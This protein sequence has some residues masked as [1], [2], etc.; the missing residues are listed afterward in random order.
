M[1]KILIVDDDADM[2]QAGRRV[3]EKEG[4]AV[5][6]APNVGAGLKALDKDAPDLL[7]LGVMMEEV[8]DGLVFARAVRRMGLT[9]P[10]LMLTSVNRAMGVSI[11]KDAEM[12]PVDEF[13]EKPVNPAVLIAKVNDLLRGERA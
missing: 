12:V 8:D 11:G 6:S 10:I 5:T 7:I 9:L 1:A 4:H 3:L 2:L 13:V